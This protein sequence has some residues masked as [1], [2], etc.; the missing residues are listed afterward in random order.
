MTPTK[1]EI[2]EMADQLGK[3]AL[4]LGRLLDPAKVQITLESGLLATLGAE[5]ALR[6]AAGADPAA[7]LELIRKL[8]EIDE[9]IEAWTR[10]ANTSSS[11]S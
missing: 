10:E 1:E 6:W 7:F 3:T 8:K 9:K 2:L 11:A 5:N 4:V